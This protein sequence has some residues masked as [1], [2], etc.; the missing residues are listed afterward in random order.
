MAPQTERNGGSRSFYSFSCLEINLTRIQN[1]FT[2]SWLQRRPPEYCLDTVGLTVAMKEQRRPDERPKICKK[3]GLSSF[4]PRR[5]SSVC[6]SSYKNKTAIANEPLKTRPV[7]PSSSIVNK[8][9]G[10]EMRR[11]LRSSWNRPHV[12]VTFSSLS[13]QATGLSTWLPI[14]L[15]FLP[16]CG[17][18]LLYDPVRRNLPAVNVHAA[19]AGLFTGWHLQTRDEEEA[20]LWWTDNLRDRRVGRMIKDRWEVRDVVPV[21]MQK[22]EN[23][24]MYVQIW[25]EGQ[26]R[27]WGSRSL[28]PTFVARH[29]KR[30]VVPF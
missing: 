12:T 16:C 7:V 6:H 9:R 10:H 27:C 2:V 22:H 1:E 23:D 11:R 28:T 15:Q 25:C 20:L 13:Q 30:S 5:P 26:S 8:E 4:F 19:A 3:I 24:L 17:D 14:M 21:W 29:K 18:P